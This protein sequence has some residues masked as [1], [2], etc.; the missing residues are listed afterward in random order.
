MLLRK[1]FILLGIV[2]GAMAGTGLSRAQAQDA[3]GLDFPE[4]DNPAAENVFQLANC[5]FFA[6]GQGQ[7]QFQLQPDNP[8]LSASS[9][10][11]HPRSELTQR[12]MRVVT[13]GYVPGGSRTGT[14][15]DVQSLG[16]IDRYIFVALQDA[17]VTP[18]DPTT[19]AEFIRR[20]TLDLTGRIPTADR[21]VAFLNDTTPGKRASL[22]EE[23]LA[24][25]QYVDKWT[26][27]F[28]DLLKNNSSNTQINRFAQGRDAFYQYIKASVAAD[29]PY[30]QLAREI[31]SAKG[32]NSYDPAQGQLNWMA[33]GVVT[34]GPAQDIWDQQAADVADTFL[35]I[36]H[37]NCLL[38]HDGRE[39]LTS[40][41]LWGGSITRYQ[42][43]QFASFESH[44]YTARTPTPTAVR[45]NP[46]YWGVQDDTK[47]KT[48]YALNTTTGN[49]PS[50]QPPGTVK[51]VAPVY[52]FN[53]ST[54]AAGSDY[55]MALAGY[56]T[57]D[58][59]FARAAVNYI[60]EQ[61]FELGLVSPSDQ[62][63]PARLDPD[64]P[65]PAPWTLQPSNARLLN[66]LA[67]DFINSKYSVKSLIREIVNSQA[68]QLSA[69]YDESSWN[70]AWE[71][72]YARKLVRRLWSEEI[73]DSVAMSSNMIPSYTISDLGTVSWAMQFPETFNMPTA[74][75]PVT[76]LLDAFL[77]GNR[78][79]Q[80]RRGDGSISQA[81]GLMNDPFVMSR[82]QGSGSSLLAKNINLPDSQMVANLFLAVLSRYPTPA[83]MATATA[84]LASGARQTEAVNL[85]W[86]LYN[87]VDFIFNY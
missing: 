76:P 9:R 78:D 33:G 4:I 30:D 16:T 49:R 82:V 61:L 25:S 43:W 6:A 87:K 31:I 41:S 48:D 40:L 10:R 64:N 44:S 56:V 19:D 17:G 28:G 79:D 54:P 32:D 37:M 71:T 60:W 15:Q 24:S 86:Q 59:Q 14:A 46:Y 5:F 68:Y 69:R 7:F 65:P 81:L 55:R 73:H 80:P 70:P 83:E 58:F 75:S 13:S 85:L 3:P 21:V 22:I 39:H 51:T 12:V 74:G 42:A 2:I 77:R 34:G 36:S 66:A 50:R 1:S 72:L 11:T 26:M 29:K 67:Q 23:L 84:N 47:Y 27:F 53:G 38:C 20:I 35:G 62:F 45:G 63:D 57:S 8:L 52:F 18:A